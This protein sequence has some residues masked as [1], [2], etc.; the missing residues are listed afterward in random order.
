MSH[1]LTSLDDIASR[2][3][4]D[5][6]IEIVEF[7]LPYISEKEQQLRESLLAA[8][9]EAAARHAHKALSSVRLFGSGKLETLLIQIRDGAVEQNAEEIQQALSAEFTDAQDAIHAWLAK[10]K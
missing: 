10:H 1:I 7:S 9:W 2:L 6:T 3:G 4:N 8:D 5:K